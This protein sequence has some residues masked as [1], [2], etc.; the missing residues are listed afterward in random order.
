[1]FQQCFRFGLLSFEPEQRGQSV[2][3]RWIIRH[4]LQNSPQ[5]FLR[6]RVIAPPRINLCEIYRHSATVA[7]G[8]ESAFVKRLFVRPIAASN[9][10]A[11]AER[12]N[13]NSRRATDQSAPACRR[14]DCPTSDK[15]KHPAAWQVKPV[16][17]HGRVELRDV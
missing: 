8:R 2:S 6:R 7:T 5:Q 3:R 11:R 10:A 1:C 4:A 14:F 13:G 12:D 15:N 16:L 9:K 17:G